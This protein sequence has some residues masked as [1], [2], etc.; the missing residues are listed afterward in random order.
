MDVRSTAINTQATFYN[1]MS[2]LQSHLRMNS[3]ANDMTRNSN[4]AS[5]LRMPGHYGANILMPHGT[6]RKQKDPNRPK[7]PT[8]AY[9]YFAQLERES[10]AKRGERISKVSISYNINYN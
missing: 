5:N 6:K 8:T 3:Y 7:R 2:N 4:Y 10:A 9:F 1:R